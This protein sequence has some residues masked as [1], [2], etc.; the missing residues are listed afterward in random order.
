MGGLQ[1]LA[2]GDLFAG[3]FRV[4]RELAR[5]GM[6]VVY[7]VDQLSTAKP[8]AL[9]LMLPEIVQDPELRRRFERE[10]RIGA[11]IESDHVVEVIGA[12]VDAATGAPW[13]AMELLAGERLDALVDRMGPLAGESARQ[14]L[15]ELCHA[16]GA[17]HRVG[18][19]HRDLKPENVFLAEARRMGVPFTVKVL[20]FGIATVVNALK[21][22]GATTRTGIGSPLWWAPEQAQ[23]GAPISPATDVWALGLLV[24]WLLTGRH[25][26]RTAYLADATFQHMAMEQFVNP[27]TVASVRAAELGAGARLPAGFD[28]WFAACVDRDPTRRPP[29]A[30]QAYAALAPLLGA[31]RA[32][33]I[34]GPISAPQAAPPPPPAPVVTPAVAPAAQWVHPGF[35]PSTTGGVSVAQGRLPGIELPPPLVQRS[36]PR[37][38]GAGR[39]IAVEAAPLACSGCAA[40]R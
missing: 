26:W 16:L 36:A 11:R 12:G 25:Y 27:L 14:I 7:V 3:D 9:K 13:L 1:S 10:A 5:G 38:G 34:S 29:D 6:G 35:A 24:F 33:P 30:S 22:T 39:A 20:D 4:V 31:S 32:A 37:R 17:A 15:G 8:R 18:V 40:T 21:S 28:A 19:V 2:P 23:L